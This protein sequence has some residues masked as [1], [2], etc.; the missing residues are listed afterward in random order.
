MKLKKS[1][2]KKCHKSN[3]MDWTPFYDAEFKPDPIKHHGFD[4]KLTIISVKGSVYCP[5]SIF[6]NMAK[7]LTG[8]IMN[9][10]SDAEKA[11]VKSGHVSIRISNS[12]IRWPVECLRPPDW[13]PHT[14]KHIMK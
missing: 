8:Y 10:A 6:Q 11:A 12:H 2:C 3:Q 9:A 14:A 5:A 13:C 4:G 7:K 1:V